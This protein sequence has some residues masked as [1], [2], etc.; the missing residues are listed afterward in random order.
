[1]RASK[2]LLIMTL[3]AASAS[4]FAAPPAPPL[5]KFEGATGVDPLTGANGVDVVNT[6]RGIAP[7]GRAWVIRKL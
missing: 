2:V 7:G 6:V 3:A 1:M 4:G 5:V